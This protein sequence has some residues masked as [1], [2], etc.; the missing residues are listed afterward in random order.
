MMRWMLLAAAL[1]ADTPHVQWLSIGAGWCPSCI[2]A[3]ADFKPWLEKSK[4]RVSDKPD[5]HI[6]LID[7]DVNPEAVVT[8]K[9]ELLPTFILLRDGVEVERHVGYPGRKYLA[10]RFIEEYRK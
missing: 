10:E 7:I 5:A 1:S 9:V 2:T 6:R 4:W 8:H 3:K